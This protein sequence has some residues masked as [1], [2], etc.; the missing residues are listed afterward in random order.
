MREGARALAATAASMRFSTSII[1]AATPLLL[2]MVGIKLFSV[3]LLT[4]S[5]WVGSA[6]GS[7]LAG[8]VGDPRRVS[9]TGLFLMGA[10]TLSLFIDPRTAFVS[11]PVAGVGAGLASSILPPLLHMLSRRE[12]PFEG[13]ASYSLS[14]SIGLV[15]AMAFTSLASLKSVRL[16][17]LASSIPSISIG[18]FLT[19]QRVD[20]P[21]V[22]VRLPGPSY[23]LDLFRKR[24]FTI[25][26]ASN[27]A[28]SLVLP[29]VLSYWSLYSL[30]VIGLGPS[31][32]FAL[33][34]IMFLTSG[35]IRASSLRLTKVREA[36]VVAE[37][38]LLLAMGLLATERYW[39]VIIGILLFSVPHSLIYP[40][41][42][43]QA[44]SSSDD[45]VK[46]NYVFSVSSGAGE[47]IS[48]IIAAVVIG[49]LGMRSI[50]G[51]GLL[52]S[53]LSMV[54]ALL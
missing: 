9:T 37:A 10:A 47:V 49:T 25:S 44:L 48:P 24:Q 52:I 40:T 35:I 51:V 13:V 22:K 50:Y 8:L 14:L 6:G 53:A 12:R 54:P 33:L 16:A 42:L 11:V 21:K 32:S 34:A 2:A 27:T 1:Q 39:P 43:Y 19:V 18:A 15:A 31:T 45:P 7:L 28:Y 38:F 5:L 23:L 17:F 30:S 29:M 26:F 4:I 46:A 20:V 3:S 36:R 41:T